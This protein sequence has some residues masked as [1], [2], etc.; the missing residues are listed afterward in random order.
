MGKSSFG[1]VVPLESHTL[2]DSRNLRTPR[3]LSFLRD[4]SSILFMF[5]MSVVVQAEEV[6]DF[7]FFE[8]KIRPVLVEHCYECHSTNAKKVHGG[9]VLDSRDS[10][11]QGGDS[12]AGV[13]PGDAAESLV[14]QALR[15]DSFEMPPSG[16]LPAEVIRD[17]ET[18]IA[19]GAPDPR[20]QNTAIERSEIDIEAGKAFWC[21][22]PISNSPLPKVAGSDWPESV[23]D[24]FLE[25]RLE[26]EGVAPVKDADRPTLL[27][28]A[29]Y[30]LVGLPPKPDEIEAFVSDQSPTPLAFATVVDRLL[31]SHHFG[32]RWGRHWL[33]V[34]RFAE[35]SGGGRTLLFPNAWRYRDYVIDAFNADMPFDQFVK[36]QIAGDLL[37]DDIAQGDW[38]T[39]RRLMVAT[40]FLLLGPTNYELQDKD[41]LEM[42]IVDEQIDTIGKAF[43]GMTIGCARCHDHKFDPIPTNDYYALAGILKSTKSVI[44]NNVSAW[45]TRK[46]PVPSQEEVRL[47][48]FE[49]KLAAL[50]EE[51][52]A[53]KEKKKSEKKSE[54][55]A[56]K[57]AEDSPLAKRIKQLENKIKSVKSNGPRWPKAMVAIDAEVAADIPVAIRGVVSNAGEIVSRGVLQ[58]ALTDDFSSIADGE[59]GRRELADWMVSSRNPLT[60][61]VIVNRVWHWLFGAGL[62][63]TVDNF[64]VMGEQPSHPDLLNHLA[65]EFIEDGW[66][67]KRLI[68]KLML[69]HAYRLS[70]V[71][72]EELA[73]HD[74]G[75]RLFGRMNRRRL[76]AESIRDTLLHVAG[77]LDLRQGGANIKPGT[78]IEYNY[79]FDSTRRSI[80]VPVFRNTLP[81]LFAT[82]D[83]ADPNIQVGK[84]MSSTIA[85]QALLLMND[86]F[87]LEQFKAAG[88]H[89]SKQEND[90]ETRVNLCFRQVLSRRPSDS[91]LRM[92]LA[93]LNDD[94]KKEGEPQRW[95]LLYQTLFQ[96]VDFRYAK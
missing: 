13:V 20:E 26:R 81:S 27:R 22:Q 1:T 41:V 45:N 87:V 51:L 29:Y 48:E 10:M 31:E 12:G 34:V 25:S 63:R 59:S 84:R 18:W 91:E 40:S 24:Q 66:S 57:E 4:R 47:N 58:V 77:R 8:K 19:N 14:L 50:E 92:A 6:S 35:S 80:Y 5:A 7:E 32:E 11:R 30:A 23:I 61:R 96:S 3:V 89:M 17:F 42:D 38:Q 90:V 70:S 46:L 76:E 15:Y 39:R 94:L 64:G 21:F 33:D 79:A 44:H 85:P 82:F 55:K 36:E 43:L 72:S 67:I 71:P 49:S 75:N 54:K 2:A 65:Y 86:P 52:A 93:F 73:K 78:K 37:A 88:L 68:R 56:K 74:S 69:T 53:K 95:A 62:V 60:A 28:R 83:F 16:K 9:L